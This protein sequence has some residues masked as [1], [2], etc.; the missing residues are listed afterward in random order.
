[1]VVP[2]AVHDEIPLVI[3][4]GDEGKVAHVDGTH[5][6]RA[7]GVDLRGVPRVLDAARPLGAVR[8]CADGAE[9]AAHADER[10][11]QPSGFGG[12]RHHL[13]GIALADA[14]DVQRHL[15]VG[16]ADRLGVLVD[17]ESADVAVLGGGIQLFLRGQ[18][19]VGLILVGF[20][21]FPVVVPDAQHT[22]HGDVQLAVGG[23]VHLL[24]QFQHPEDPVVHR[25]RIGT[26][27]VVDGL[28][29]D[30]A[31]VVVVDV[32]ELVVGHQ[33]GV[34]GVHLRGEFL[35]AVAVGDDLRD[36]VK[37]VVKDCAVP[38]RAIRGSGRR[39]RS[40][41]AAAR[42]QACTEGSR[43]KKGGKTADVH[44]LVVSFA[45]VK[46]ACSS[47]RCASRSPK[48]QFL[49]VGVTTALRG[50]FTLA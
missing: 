26:G 44:A 43:R 2:H 5:I 38:L 34:Q 7:G 22:A 40:R 18:G 8:L 16:Q 50:M 17:D 39:R 19:V 29:V 37:G 21:G 49:L 33:I 24:R 31:V 13:D 9:I 46:A 32:V 45:A 23:I 42:Q 4:A 6:G 41:A 47:C 36:G 27:M 10:A 11:G 28:D 1:M 12:L 35:L 25:H 30:D 15:R 20:G 14:A 3:A 48:T